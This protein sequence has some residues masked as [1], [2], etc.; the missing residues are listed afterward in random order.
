MQLDWKTLRTEATR[1]LVHVWEN[2]FKMNPKNGCDNRN[3]E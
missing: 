1:K 3:Y 2:N